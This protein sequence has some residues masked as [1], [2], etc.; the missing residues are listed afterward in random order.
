MS[1]EPEDGLDQC[2]GIRRAARQEGNNTA[3]HIRRD[4]ASLD[5]RSHDE[6]RFSN[7]KR[8]G[9]GARGAAEMNAQVAMPVLVH[10]IA[11]AVRRIGVQPHDERD[12]RDERDQTIAAKTRAQGG[13]H[14]S[15]GRNGPAVIPLA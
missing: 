6:H 11:E 10:A 8:L 15:R 5:R 2:G 12:G 3:A 7:G 14:L 1:Y 9:W 13:A 4:G